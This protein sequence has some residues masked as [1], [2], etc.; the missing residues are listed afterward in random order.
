MK[1]TFVRKINTGILGIKETLEGYLGEMAFCRAGNNPQLHGHVHEVMYRMLYNI[2]PVNVVRGSHMEL[3]KSHTA[4]VK[5]VIAMVGRKVSGHAQ[6]KDCSSYSGLRDVVKRINRGQYMKTRIVCTE[7]TVKGLAGKARQKVY[8]S[9]ISTK[10]THR[11]AGKVLGKY[12]CAALHEAGIVGAKMGGLVSAGLEGITSGYE[13]FKG[14]KSG[15][16]A[17]LDTAR[18]G[19]KGSVSGYACT[20]TSSFV[21]ASIV[22][23]VKGTAIATAVGA[24]TVTAGAVV[25]GTAAAIGVGHYAWKISERLVG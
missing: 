4:T 18:S 20:V 10:T 7:E 1:K 16:R 17:L 3:T 12:S 25:L 24:S 23:A 22:S 6:L 19:I 2:N 21:T 13:W 11:I 5:D 9:G 14:R 15:K 8:S